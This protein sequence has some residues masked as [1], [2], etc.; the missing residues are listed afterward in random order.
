MVKHL[1]EKQAQYQ[2]NTIFADYLTKQQWQKTK[3]KTK[4]LLT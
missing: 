3:K 2:K 1:K 4:K